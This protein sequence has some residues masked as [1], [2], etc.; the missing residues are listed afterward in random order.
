MSAANDAAAALRRRR[1]LEGPILP[2]L[3]A[4][5]G[6]TVVVLLVQ[7][8]V[9]VAET[10]FVSN[11]GTAALAGVA[12][13]FPALMLMQMMSNG[14]IGGGVSSAVARAI[15]AGRGR[16]A[17]ALVLNALAVAIVLGLVFTAAEL[18]WGRALFTVMGGR[19]GVLAAALGY[20][21]IVFAGSVLIWITSL[22]AAALRGSGNVVVPAIVTL[23]GAVIV[24]PLSPALIFGWGPLPRMGVAGAGIAVI[25]YYLAATL[26][27]FAYLRAGRGALRLPLDPRLVQWR[28]LADILRVGGLSALGTVQMNL[29]VTLVTGL[30]G[31]FGADAVAGYGVASRLDYLLIP[32]LFSVGT[33][34]LTMVG[35]NIGARQF[36]RARRIAWTAALIGAGLTEAIGVAAAVFPQA[37][38]GIFT[39]EPAVL[40]AGALYFRS[41]A[42][43]YGLVGLGMLLYFSGQG[44][45]R[46]FWPFIGGTAR[47]AI[48]GIGGWLAI[49]LWGQGL[50]MLFGLVAAASIS[51]GGVTA[52][53]MLIS[54]WGPKPQP[55]RVL[56]PE[57][58]EV[59]T[60][61]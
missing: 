25:I 42:P 27:L 30:V 34:S 29:T 54:P 31:R 43:F 47:L 49:A 19:D 46:V 9:G 2:T 11:L 22:F 17:D 44:A 60:T 6:P 24:V 41:V 1:I 12:L 56:E 32:L 28:L 20:A 61:T 26:A 7:T 14:G 45:G 16:D 8:G 39:G 35:T 33:A 18:L 37:W 15:G 58:E 4:L 50:G 3:L 48:A 38:L 10:Y 51:Y 55:A 40:T 57:R 36:R 5:A 13:V 23:A 59:A 52:L 53:A 21:D